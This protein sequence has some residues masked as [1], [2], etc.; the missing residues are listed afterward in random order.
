MKY[1]EDSIKREFNPYDPFCETE[2]EVSLGNVG[3]V[4][5]IGLNE[6]YL[7]VT[8]FVVLSAT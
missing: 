1:F 7:K 6:G 4:P 3:D 2:Y 5:S 8:R